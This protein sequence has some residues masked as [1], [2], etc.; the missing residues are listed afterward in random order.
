MSW[1]VVGLSEIVSRSTLSE[2]TAGSALLKAPPPAIP[3]SIYATSFNDVAVDVVAVTTVSG[4]VGSKAVALA[5][6]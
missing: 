1:S 3:V 4:V 6:L 5:P 2:N